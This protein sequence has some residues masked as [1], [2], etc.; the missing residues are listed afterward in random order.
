MGGGSRSAFS[1]CRRMRCRLGRGRLYP[2]L[3]RLEYKGL[4][5]GGLGGFGEQSQGQVLFADDGK[6][7]K[8]LKVELKK[9][10]RLTTAIALGDSREV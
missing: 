3:H 9:W 5:S 10:E 6:A 1:R 2:A 8:Q 4:D 7:Q